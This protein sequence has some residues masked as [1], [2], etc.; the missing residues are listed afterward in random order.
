MPISD[1]GRNNLDFFGLPT[2]ETKLRVA[3]RRFGNSPCTK[4]LAYVYSQSV[5]SDCILDIYCCICFYN[6][7]DETHPRMIIDE[8]VAMMVGP[9]SMEGS[10]SLTLYE[11]VASAALLCV[12]VRTSV[13]TTLQCT[14]E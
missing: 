3:G 1:R 7:N 4:L 2:N 10:I 8:N 14:S 9:L 5:L 11:H 13:L 12:T 6:Q